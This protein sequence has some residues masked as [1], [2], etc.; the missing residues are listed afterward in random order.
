MNF[1]AN[2][3]SM[4]RLRKVWYYCCFGFVP[5]LAG[6]TI[7]RY[8]AEAGKQSAP[9]ELEQLG[10]SHPYLMVVGSPP[11]RFQEPPLPLGSMDPTPVAPPPNPAT[12]PKP[13]SAK[14]SG[15]PPPPPAKPSVTGGPKPNSAS[16]DA[17]TSAGPPIGHDQVLPS[18]IPDEM[19][20]RVRPEEFLPFFQLPGSGQQDGPAHEAPPA[21][22]PSSATY[23][24]E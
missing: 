14:A 21:L 17:V 11:L 3:P 23:R 9:I 19:R 13:A 7:E 4:V 12:V 18:I 20:P 5:A 10:P 24:K 1:R 16:G 8:Y 15:S 22:P 2:K 6:K